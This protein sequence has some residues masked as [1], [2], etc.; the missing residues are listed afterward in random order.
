MKRPAE[1]RGVFCDGFSYIFITLVRALFV[2][3]EGTKWRFLLQNFNQYGHSFLHDYQYF[4][5]NCN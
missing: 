1:K 4:Y 5:N 2:F 3:F